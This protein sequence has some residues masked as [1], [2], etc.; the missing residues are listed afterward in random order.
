M[1]VQLL[2]VVVAL[3]VVLVLQ[4]VVLLLQILVLVLADTAA[5]LRRLQCSGAEG[6]DGDAELGAEGTFRI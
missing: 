4:V 6:C 2:V 1:F 3:G 5:V